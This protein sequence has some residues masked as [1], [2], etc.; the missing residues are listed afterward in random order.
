M[1]IADNLF[2][3][4]MHNKY[5]QKQIPNINTRIYYLRCI[6]KIEELDSEKPRV[7]YLNFIV[8]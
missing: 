1:H 5:Y 4:K 8:I 7:K 2:F 3:H 6:H